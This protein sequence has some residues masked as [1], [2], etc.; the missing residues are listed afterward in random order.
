MM[1][2]HHCS[3]WVPGITNKSEKN[4]DGVIEKIVK[5]SIHNSEG[6]KE[7]AVVG[8]KKKKSCSFFC[9]F[10]SFDCAI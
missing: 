8:E 1:T 10:W 9:R 2:L 4:E 5:L 3:K 6:T 7:F